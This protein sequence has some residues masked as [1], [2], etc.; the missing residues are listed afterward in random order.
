MF[1]KIAFT[2]FAFATC[3]AF[4]PQVHAGAMN[5]NSLNSLGKTFYDKGK[6]DIEEYKEGDVDDHRKDVRRALR[7][8]EEDLQEQLR[9]KR[10]QQQKLERLQSQNPD[11]R[12]REA[13][14]KQ[15]QAQERYFEHMQ[16]QHRDI[17]RKIE[18]SHK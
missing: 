9:E 3:L 2:T 5:K 18:E 13:Y 11:S 6:K 7:D 16:K 4:A 12:Q 8:Q 14:E 10:R 15:N 17:S 1:K